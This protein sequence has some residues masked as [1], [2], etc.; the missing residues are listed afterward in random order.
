MNYNTTR[1]IAAGHITM[2]IKVEE[3]NH[4]TEIVKIRECTIIPTQTK[5]VQLTFKNSLHVAFKIQGPLIQRAS[6][7]G[8]FPFHFLQKVVQVYKP[9]N[10][11]R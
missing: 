6:C 1:K 7:K 8:N 4:F 11:N 9:R 5:T 3:D 2:T 10:T